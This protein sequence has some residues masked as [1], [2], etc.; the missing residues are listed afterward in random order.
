[1]DSRYEFGG[2]DPRRCARGRP[3]GTCTAHVGR[4]R[5]EVLDTLAAA[6]GEQGRFADALHAA[7]RAFEMATAQHRAALAG[8]VQAQKWPPFEWRSRCASSAERGSSRQ[9]VRWTLVSMAPGWSTPAHPNVLAVSDHQFH[10]VTQAS[11]ER[12]SDCRSQATKTRALAK[13]VL[14]YMLERTRL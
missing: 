12:A 13:V 11:S 10:D 5:S 2:I 9:R 6:Y 7:T 1:M 14:Y 4:A 8:R 3:S